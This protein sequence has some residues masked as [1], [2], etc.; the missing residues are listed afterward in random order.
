M[1]R[2]TVREERLFQL[3]WA[4]EKIQKIENT[5][6]F[7]AFAWHGDIYYIEATVYN[8]YDGE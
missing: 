2:L 1:L 4:T 6:N 5:L 3:Q 7:S 8:I